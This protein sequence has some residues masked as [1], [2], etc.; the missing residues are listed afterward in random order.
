MQQIK[1]I[2]D[3]VRLR[4]QHEDDLWT[5]AQMV[6]PGCRVGMSG[7]R[8]DQSTGTQ[9]GGRAKAADRKP[10]WIVLD[11]ESS[12]FQPF[13]DN[14]RIHGIIAE[15]PQDKGSHHTHAVGPRDEIEIT[16][17]GGVTDADRTL[18]SEAL[19]DSGRGH[20]VIA[21]VE[22]DEIILFEIAQHGMRDVS[23]FTLRGGGKRE[24]KS[25]EVRNAFLA[26][27]AKDTS[28]IFSAEM[29]III[30]G[31]G[32]AREQFESLLKGQGVGHQTL[33]IG[34]SIGGR[35]A[36]NEVMREG[37]ADAVLGEFAMAKQVQVIEQALERIASRGA[38]AYGRDAIEAAVEQGAVESLVIEAGLL[39]SDDFWARAAMQIREANGEIIQASQDHDAGEQLVSM[40]GALALLR[41]TM[42]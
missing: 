25:Q 38:V 18:L 9:E 23:M 40:G 3:G 36:A 10:M 33:N 28:M 1:R 24:A 16:W 6:R 29:P 35:A 30:C 8:R 37:T 2:E 22:S 26:G 13:T 41:W 42:D 31:P 11:A 20:A 21:V 5:L 14:L 17:T 7:F 27:A 19:K 34:T 39:R 12:E 15:A 32:M 4:V